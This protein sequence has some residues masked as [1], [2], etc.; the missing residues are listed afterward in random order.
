MIIYIKKYKIIISHI[1]ITF[2]LGCENSSPT[3]SQ[4]IDPQ[5]IFSSRR[6]W[7]YDI[8]IANVYG[9]NI[10]QITKNKWIDFNPSISPDASKLLFVSDRNGNRE[11][12]I[13]DLEWLD[14]YT[15]W[16]ANNLTNLTNSTENDWTP[17]YSPVENKI[18]YST[19]FPENDNYDIFIMNDDGSNKTNLTNSKSYEKFPQFSPDGSFIIYQGWDK[20]KMEIFFTNLL[21]KNR[22][23]ITRNNKSDDIISHGNSF[24]PDGQTLVFTS[25][26]DGNRNIYTSKINGANLT[27]I[28]N[29]QAN[30]YEPVFSPDGESIIFTSERDKNKEIYLFDLKTSKIKN[31]TNNPYDDWNA[32]YYPDSQKIV[33]QSIRDGNWEI[34]IMSLNGRNQTN[35]S[36]HPSTDYSYIVLPL[37][38]P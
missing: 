21:D 5:I 36:N 24:S 2:F 23:N 25:E 31:L 33:F 27:Q 35:L 11:I 32:R 1:I 14:G 4:D 18:I 8:F 9:G 20:G 16:R 30:D 6:W 19:Y 15:Q 26:R 38:N 28:T 22:I 12:F 29:H 37:I 7:N 10:T 34:Y 13:S 17:A 3:L